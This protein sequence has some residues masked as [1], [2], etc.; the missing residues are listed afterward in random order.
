LIDPLIT[1]KL[2]HT[3]TRCVEEGENESYMSSLLPKWD[4]LHVSRRKHTGRDF[5]MTG[6]LDKYD[7]EGIMLDLGSDVNIFPKKSWEL[8]GKPKLVW[9]PIQLRLANKYRIYPI[10]KLEKVEVNINGFKTKEYFE[11]IERMDVLV[12]YPYF[13]GINWE[14]DNNVVLDLK[15]R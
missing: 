15:Q 1:K 2:T 5:K 14:F 3:L 13:L 9:F 12:P 11:V 6:D 8:M 7:M 4:M 10:G